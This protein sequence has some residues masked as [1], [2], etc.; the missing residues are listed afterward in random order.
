M[1]DEVTQ[2]IDEG[3]IRSSD[4]GIAAAVQDDH[5][6]G[7]GL[8]RE[9]PDEATLAR[10]GL[11]PDHLEALSLLERAWDQRVQRGELP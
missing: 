7:G 4:D 5:P 8:V 1:L 6:S 2:C 11:S 9:L 3:S 10:P